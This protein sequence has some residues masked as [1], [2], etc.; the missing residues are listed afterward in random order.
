MGQFK[1]VRYFQFAVYITFTSTVSN[2]RAKSTTAQPLFSIQQESSDSS[3]CSARISG[4]NA[5]SAGS[6]LLIK[7]SH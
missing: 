4:E 5:S 6:G 3:L 7:L 2:K 1:S